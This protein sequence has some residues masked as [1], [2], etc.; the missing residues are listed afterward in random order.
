VLGHGESKS[1]VVLASGPQVDL[2]PF[3]SENLGAALQYFTGSKAHNVALRERAVRRGL[4][5]NEYGVFR[6][7]SGDRLAGDSEEGVYSTLGLPFIPPE[8]REDRGEIAA[9]EAGRLPTLTAVEDL[10]GDLHS[11][12]TESDGR[13]TIEAMVEAARAAGLAY[14]AVT[15]HSRA[16]P[17]PAHGTGMDEKRCLA[18]IR[19]IRDLGAKL[20][21]F[22]LLAGIEVDILPDGRL[23]MDDEVLA[24]LDVVVASLHSRLNM[25]AAE[26]T[27]RVLRAFENPHVHVWGHPLARLIL[28][29][30]PVALDVERVLAEAVRRGVALEI[31]G[32]PDRLDLPD[33]WIR[34]AR[35]M[36]ARF[37]ISSDAHSVRQLANL[38][39][40][41]GQARR[42]WLARGEVLNALDAPA[43]RAA[44]R[45][46][47]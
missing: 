27:D 32:Q 18:H 26:M 9:A 10:R 31:N 13:D 38:R 33:S 11:H 16:I 20:D 41:V 1:S 30:E 36:G 19:R 28:T 3:A 46:A 15:D 22:S 23:D 29:R 44:L 34:S 5:L 40:G 24:Q 43:L 25:E 42:G 45:T 2:R 6:A 17:S 4:K 37:A 12:T 7:E 39:Y 8:M 35:D 21:H 47:G 14:L